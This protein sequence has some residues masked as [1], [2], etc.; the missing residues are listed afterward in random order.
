M[1]EMSTLVFRRFIL[2][3]PS[4]YS[5]SSI[6]SQLTFRGRYFSEGLPWEKTP[7]RSVRVDLSK[8]P[9][10]RW[11]QQ[12]REEFP[13]LL[14]GEEQNHWAGMY[15]LGLCLLWGMLL[16]KPVFFSLPF[17]CRAYISVEVWESACSLASHSNFPGWTNS[18]CYGTGFYPSPCKGRSDSDEPMAT[19]EQTQQVTSLCLTSGGGVW[20]VMCTVESL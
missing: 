18:S 16:I 3:R 1:S 2:C 4:L 11:T 17:H 19:W 6:S 5:R 12:Q 14:E 9:A 7:Y 8:I 13:K 10:Q 20:W 15:T